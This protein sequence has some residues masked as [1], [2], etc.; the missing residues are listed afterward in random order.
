MREAIWLKEVCAMHGGLCG[1][2]EKGTS[3]N[4]NVK[5]VGRIYYLACWDH[6]HMG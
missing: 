1:T 4:L 6:E 3:L 2:T 5:R